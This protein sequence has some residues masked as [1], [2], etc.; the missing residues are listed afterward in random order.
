M[1]F[2]LLSLC[3]DAVKATRKEIITSTWPTHVHVTNLSF[4]P[5]ALNTKFATR[6]SLTVEIS[7]EKAQGRGHLGLH[8]TGGIKSARALQAV[9]GRYIWQNGRGVLPNQLP[10]A[11]LNSF[12][13]RRRDLSAPLRTKEEGRPTLIALSRKSW[14][15]PFRVG[16]KKR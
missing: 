2:A 8:D 15:K 7:D 3:N 11:L 1:L 16:W 4:I 10:R 5:W 14:S 12:K 6:R 9:P 13:K